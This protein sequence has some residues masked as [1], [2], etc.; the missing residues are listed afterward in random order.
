MLVLAGRA[1]ALAEMAVVDRKGGDAIARQCRGMHPGHLFL[2]AR[3][4]LGHDGG[5]MRARPVG[6]VQ[7]ADQPFPVDG[8]AQPL[9]A[10]HRPISFL[11]RESEAR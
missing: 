10:R 7:V 4:R 6:Q 11:R 2:H 8:E 5:G 9:D 3:H 1:L